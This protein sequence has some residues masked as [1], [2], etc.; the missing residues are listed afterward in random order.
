MSLTSEPSVY[1]KS[2]FLSVPR[3]LVSVPLCPCSVNAFLS[4]VFLSSS[5]PGPVCLHP[6]Q[7]HLAAA[8][9]LK[10]ETVRSDIESLR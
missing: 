7:S 1:L 10:F 8:C 4:R 6:H 2:L 9:L 3:H 5:C